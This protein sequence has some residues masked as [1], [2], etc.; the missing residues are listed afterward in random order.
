MKKTLLIIILFINQLAISQCN[1]KLLNGTFENIK[2]VLK[3]P[4]YS[5]NQESKNFSYIKHPF[6]KGNIEM[7]KQD[8]IKIDSIVK[9]II[10]KDASNY[11]W[12]KLVFQSFDKV[13]KDS[14]G[15]FRNNA[16]KTDL[17]KCKAK[18][19]IH[20]YFEPIE[21]VKYCIGYAFDEGLN[22]IKEDRVSYLVAYDDEYGKIIEY[23][24]YE[25]VKPFENISI[26]SLKELGKHY[27][28]NDVE[29]LELIFLKGSFYW[30]MNE[31][32]PQSIGENI[33]KSVL[34][35]PS[36]LKDYIIKDARVYIEV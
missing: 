20:Y 28:N 6:E 17:D 10:L 27:L 3:C 15:S 24:S 32:K 23:P 34:I 9:N 7:V 36:D 13:Y 1:E 19:S 5:Y 8:Y 16:L 26:C 11:F 18:Y 29:N 35:N 21:N 14:I 31:L 22:W 33:V 12:S 30:K 4:T 25:N 2:Y